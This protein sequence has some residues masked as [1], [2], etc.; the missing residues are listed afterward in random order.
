M[1]ASLAATYT[2]RDG[3]RVVSAVSRVVEHEVGRLDLR[4]GRRQVEDGVSRAQPEGDRDVDAVRGRRGRHQAEQQG[5]S[6]HGEESRPRREKKWIKRI[7]R[8]HVQAV[9][10]AHGQT[11]YSDGPSG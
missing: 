4:L 6:Q 3:L 11:L 1:L 2:S 8:R 7:T 9:T 10:A 5:R